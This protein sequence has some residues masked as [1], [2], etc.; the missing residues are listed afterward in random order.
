MRRK[1]ALLTALYFCQGLPGGFLA[2][3]MPVILRAQGVDLKSIGLFSMLSLPWALKVLW[4]PLVDRYGHEGFGFRKSWLVPAQLGM[5]ATVLA[6]AQTDPVVMLPTVAV[7]FLVL[8]VF[9]ATQD[10][11]V[12]GLAVD[13]LEDDELG[14]GNSAQIAGFKLGN[15]FGGGVLLALTAWLGWRGDFYVMAAALLAVIAVVWVYREAPRREAAA[16]SL[17]AVLRRLGAAL[18]RAGLGVG[19]FLLFA[20]FGETLGGA[21]IKPMLYDN[22]FSFETIGLVEGVGGGLS[23]IAGAALGGALAYRLGWR[24]ALAIAATGQGLALAGIGLLAMGPVTLASYLPLAIA[25]NAFGGAVGVSVFAFGMGLRDPAVGASWFT[26][27]Q[28][29]YMAGG[30]L[31][32]PTAGFM[33]DSLSYTPV[34]LTGGG[35]TIALA[36]VCVT[37]AR[38]LERPRA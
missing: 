5:L 32:G 35:L 14:P 21:M 18:R 16:P 34:M 20:K 11:A 24:R 3:A 28:V 23:T 10:I 9:A 33:A 19:A 15:V 1:L 7:L 2:G 38:R 37:V 29:M 31:A 17:E 4:A 22:H 30:F 6:L 25:E 26:A 36:V 12:D 8:N 27:V 13:L